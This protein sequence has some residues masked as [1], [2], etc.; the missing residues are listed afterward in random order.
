MFSTWVTYNSRNLGIWRENKGPLDGE[1]YNVT[2]VERRDVLD[3][4]AAYIF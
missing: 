4:H 3:K 1:N 2:T